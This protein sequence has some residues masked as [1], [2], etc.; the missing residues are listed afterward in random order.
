MLFLM[1]SSSQLGHCG[2]TEVCGVPLL[3]WVG[4]RGGGS[5][6]RASQ[7]RNALMETQLLKRSVWLKRIYCV[8]LYIKDYIL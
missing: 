4:D 6:Q 3:T 1:T 8:T 5:L 2:R 7:R